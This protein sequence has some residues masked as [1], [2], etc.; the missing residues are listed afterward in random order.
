MIQIERETSFM[1][2]RK[3]T[4]IITTLIIILV[5]LLGILK[6][7][8]VIYKID[9]CR[10]YLLSMFSNINQKDRF[11]IVYPSLEKKYMRPYAAR[12]ENLY[13][14][15]QMLFYRSSGNEKVSQISDNLLK[16]TH[17]YRTYNLRKAIIG[18]NALTSETISKNDILYIPHSLPAAVVD[19]KKSS[20]PS[21]PPVRGLYFTGNSLGS[22]N[23]IK[24]LK[25][26]RENGINTIVFDVKDIPG[27][28][29][30][31]S[32]VPAVQELDTHNKRT[33]DDIAAL[34]RI[35]K[36]LDYYVI[37]RTAV[38]RDHLLVKKKPEYAIQSRST[39]RT[40]NEGSKELW[41]DPTNKYVQDYNIAI[42][43]ELAHY[44]VDEI[45]FD[46]IRFPTVGN[47]SDA[48][49]AW[50]FG[51]M[52]KE[53]VIAQFL[54][55]ASE[56]LHASNTRVSIDIFGV[57]AWGKS[58]D[59]KKTG[60]KIELLARYCDVISPMLYPSHFNDDFDGF[61]KPG[62]N[63]YYFIYQGCKR[64]KARA[65]NT[66]VRPWLQ[67]FKWRVSNYNEDYILK[68]V[69]AS[70]DAGAGGYLFWNAGNDYNTVLR[71]M[72]S[73]KTTMEH[74]GTAK[75]LTDPT[76]LTQR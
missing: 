7:D 30:Y 60:Q 23:F 59:I 25:S 12:V 36:S 74:K 31:L 72:A 47:L 73:L 3:S 13:H 46:Y 49:Y 63:P 34:I 28:I 2:N 51:K 37:A 75:N 10:G 22:Y 57:V 38:F 15:G 43:L 21:I 6:K 1:A 76:N 35:F 62:D 67:A 39:G 69:K 64:V 52:Q 50:H 9:Y 18:A 5:I 61:N 26:L 17:Y 20:M 8:Y 42:A 48:S 32:H 56:E 16:Y 27:I 44:G 4:I 66:R 70:N 33:V 29:S 65:G 40:W 24:S 41:C 55:R 19:L 53:E 45:Q 14:S 58:V 11:T 54:K 68:Q 71:A